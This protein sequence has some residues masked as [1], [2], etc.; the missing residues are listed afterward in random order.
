MSTENTLT[1]L[2]KRLCSMWWQF[3]GP[4]FK[5]VELLNTSTRRNI[6][7]MFYLFKRGTS[8]THDNSTQ[9]HVIKQR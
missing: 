4:S 1:Y 9:G 8:D 5:T 3:P 2:N 7:K 6:W